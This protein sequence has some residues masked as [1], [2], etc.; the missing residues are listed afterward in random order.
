[1]T[2]ADMERRA[3]MLETD[4]RGLFDQIETARQRAAS[5]DADDALMALSM[6][7]GYAESLRTRLST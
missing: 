6:L 7:S 3:E 4:L 5:G 1:M 2:R